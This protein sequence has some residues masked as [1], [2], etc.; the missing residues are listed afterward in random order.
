M[1]W[2]SL[3]LSLIITKYAEYTQSPFWL[4]ANDTLSTHAEWI[5][6]RFLDVWF[7]G[8]IFVMCILLPL[9]LGRR[10]AKGD[11]TWQIMLAI[12]KRSLLLILIGWFFNGVMRLDGWESFRIMGVLQKIGI[13]YFVVATLTL[14]LRTR[15]LAIIAILSFGLYWWLLKYCHVPGVGAGILTPEGN[16]AYYIDRVLLLPSQMLYRG[17]GDP[18][19]I[20]STISTISLGLI[21]VLVGVLLTMQ[22]KIRNSGYVKFGAI[23]LVGVTLLGTAYLWH[24]Y[25]PI[26]KKIWTSS[27]ILE[28]A[29]IL[30]V[31]L[32]FLYLILDVW[33][34][35][36]WAYPLAVIG[37]NP[38]LMYLA[39]EIVD[40]E[41]V[42][43]FFV[44]G[45]QPIYLSAFPLILAVA[46]FTIKWIILAYMY[47]KKIC[48]K[49]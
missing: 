4:H 36:F 24:P 41:G 48:I 29:G 2:G 10:K 40:F 6:F 37:F 30:S 38:L 20:L 12:I 34:I 7:P 47:Q 26:I 27:Y 46:A 39:A 33:K 44:G 21:G 5:G 35:R 11:K 28:C 43:R 18:E 15:Y 19:G 45:L 1:L 13:T 42:A 14:F 25:M 8:F 31:M 23:L 3:G 32:S 22:M 49:I 17:L 9:V 16:I